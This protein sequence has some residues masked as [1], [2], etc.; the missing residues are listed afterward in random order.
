M[1]K[2]KE[3]PEDVHKRIAPL[4][5]AIGYVAVHWARLEHEINQAIWALC[6]LESA[7]GACLTAQI[8][9]IMPRMRALIALVHKNGC[10]EKLLTD[11]NRFAGEADKLAR[12]RN[13]VIHDPWYF[14]DDTNQ[15]FG[16][17]EVTADKRLVYEIKLQTRKDVLDIAHE[18]IA[19]QKTFEALRARIN[20]EFQAQLESRLGTDSEGSPDFPNP[21]TET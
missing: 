5:E 4:L 11:L 17:L 19:A 1:S 8:P 16:R 15:I 18:I 21:D 12:R 7:D 20:A 14:R 13:R 2:Q 9:S 10:G 6:A 3:S